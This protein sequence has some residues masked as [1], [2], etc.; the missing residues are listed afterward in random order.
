M[1]LMNIVCSKSLNDDRDGDNDDVGDHRESLKTVEAVINKLTRMTP[2]DLITVINS[3]HM[4]TLFRCWPTDYIMELI[5]IVNKISENG[6]SSAGSHLAGVLI[7]RGLC[8]HIGELTNI[9]EPISP[10]FLAGSSRYPLTESSFLST[11]EFMKTTD[12]EHI[13][14]FLDN[15]LRVAAES[16]VASNKLTGLIRTM[17]SSMASNKDLLKSIA[18]S[19]VQLIRSHLAKSDKIPDDILQTLNSILHEDSNTTNNKDK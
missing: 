10:T 19:T 9:I 15:C 4:D 13:P 17:A 14:D 2:Q 7:N 16:P 3:P 11:L 5:S 6:I 12:P 1:H 8:D 18:P